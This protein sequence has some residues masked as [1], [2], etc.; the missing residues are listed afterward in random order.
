MSKRI[1]R[2]APSGRTYYI[3]PRP[4]VDL[5]ETAYTREQ[6]MASRKDLPPVLMPG[7]N[8]ADGWEPELPDG[9]GVLRP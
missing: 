7:V 6:I 8:P 4:S 9:V 2:V 5:V 3:A 1:K